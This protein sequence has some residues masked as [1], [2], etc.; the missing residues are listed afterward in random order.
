MTE[1]AGQ[2][3]IAKWIRANKK[4]VLKFWLEE[5]NWE[6]NGEEFE[7]FADKNMWRESG[8]S[9]SNDSYRYFYHDDA[10]FF[11]SHIKIVKMN[12][13]TSVCMEMV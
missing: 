2:K 4:K 8:D 12:G 5:S 13:K 6:L 7:E 1:E 3:L 9:L 10:V 11:Y